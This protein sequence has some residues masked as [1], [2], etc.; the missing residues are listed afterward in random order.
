MQ[1]KVYLSE[2]S[3]LPF[4]AFFFFLLPACTT[5]CFGLVAS[6]SSNSDKSSSTSSGRLRGELLGFPLV[7]EGREG[8]R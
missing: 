7:K 4:P 8:V 5:F 1:Q 6:R 3:N 2:S